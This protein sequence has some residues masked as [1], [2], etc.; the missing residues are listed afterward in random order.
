MMSQR[1]EK[2]V[3]DS[4][5]EQVHILSPADLNGYQRLFGGKLMEWIDIV[6]G[7]V[8]RRHSEC[9]VTTAV[10]DTLQ[11]KGP[12]Y[13]NETIVLTG[14]LTYVGRTSMEVCVT[15]YVEE[16]NGKKRLINQAY[17]VMVALDE[18]ERPTEVS[19]LI[20]T[21]DEEKQ[22][23]DAALK[24]VTVRKMRDAKNF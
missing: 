14:K 2:T 12:A 6:S 9:N 17:S 5:T 24:R 19:G 18:H 20:L 3:Q 8:A 11:F 22:E 13:T 23:W 15:T 1:R 4:Y 10:V 21:T 7:V 16:L